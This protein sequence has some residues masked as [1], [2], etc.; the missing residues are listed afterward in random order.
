MYLG[1]LLFSFGAIATSIPNSLQKDEL[2][3]MYLLK[4]L[5]NLDELRLMY[6]LKLLLLYNFVSIVIPPFLI[7]S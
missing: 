5:F 1:K 3:S 4:L 6:L 7:V 2:R